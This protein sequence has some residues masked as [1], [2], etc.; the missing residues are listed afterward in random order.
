M[1]A[2]PS[3]DY[4][5]VIAP[6]TPA[7]KYGLAVHEQALD[8]IANHFKVSVCDFPSVYVKLSAKE[9]ADEIN[10]LS[11]QKNCLAI[12]AAIGGNDS[13]TLLRHL[14][15]EA[16]SMSKVPFVGYSDNTAIHNFLWRLGRTSYYGGSTQL[17]IGPGRRIDP[18][19]LQS[20]TG[21]LNKG[22]RVQLSTPVE[23]EIRGLDWQLE[24][25]LNAN[26]KRLRYPAYR[27]DG[28]ICVRKGPT[29]GGCVQT[30]IQLAVMGSM[31]SAEE[32]RGAVLFLEL[33]DDHLGEQNLL[34]FVRALGE[35]GYFDTVSALLFGIPPVG[36]VWA[37]GLIAPD[38]DAA[39]ALGEKIS[40]QIAGYNE[41]LLRVFGLPFG[42]L[43]PQYIIPYGG[44]AI[45]DSRKRT[46]EID[47]A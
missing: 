36:K 34:K 27:W 19:Q 31:P 9:R 29:W 7:A 13:I 14:D 42:H 12:F 4:I 26:G 44:Q 10:Y 6:S 2:L 5:A 45:V 38:P 41:G 20:L 21:I 1:R 17:Q 18:E 40:D 37:D 11:V 22:K 24:S 16:L 8:R 15:A 23:Y 30:L 28:E 47:Y 35:A 43:R 46:V 32:L 39:V 33:S 3:E 25:A